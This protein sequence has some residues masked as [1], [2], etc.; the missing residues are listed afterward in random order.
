MHGYSGRWRALAAV[1]LAVLV[2]QGCASTAGRPL[3]TGIA[4][5]YGPGFDGKKTASGEIFNRRALTAAHKTLP[6]DTRVRVVNLENGKSVVVRINDRG[7]FVG[8]RIID[9]SERAAREIDMIRSGTARVRLELLDSPQPIRSGSDLG[10]EEFTIQLA[11]FGDRSQATATASR[12]DGARVEPAEVSG[13]PVYRV[14]YGSFAS[15]E[16]AASDLQR[17]RRLGHAGFIKQVQN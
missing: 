11:S 2:I 3:Q 6:F 7:P 4:S 17:L 16:G 10:R 9:L 1:A 5:W 12:V 13:R 15:R 14:Y 8:N